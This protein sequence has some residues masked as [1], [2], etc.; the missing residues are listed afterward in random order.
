MNEGV[1]R[2]AARRDARGIERLIQDAQAE[3][4]FD[5]LACKG[6]PLRVTFGG[7]ATVAGLK[8]ALPSGGCPLTPRARS[9]TSPMWTLRCGNPFTWIL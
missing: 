8:L 4:K 1:R 6:Q 3:G 9:A 5:D 7:S 2:A